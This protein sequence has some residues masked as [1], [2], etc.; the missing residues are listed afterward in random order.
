MLKAKD[1]TAP[2]TSVNKPKLVEVVIPAI[3][4]RPDLVILAV[5]SGVPAVA[6]TRIPDQ[7]IRDRT[8]PLLSTVA[9]VIV[10]VVVVTTAT[11]AVRLNKVLLPLPPALLTVAVTTAV[12]SN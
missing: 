12:G 11:P 2:P 4:A 10:I 9:T 6:R 8:E 1:W 5:A 3:G 7:V